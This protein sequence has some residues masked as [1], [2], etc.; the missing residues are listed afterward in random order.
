[1]QK[2]N[3]NPIYLIETILLLAMLFFFGFNFIKNSNHNAI[4]NYPSKTS[5]DFKEM[6]RDYLRTDLTNLD[7]KKY[8]D[9]EAEQMIQNQKN[10]YPFLETCLTAALNEKDLVRKTFYFKWA[11]NYFNS[12]PTEYQNTPAL[13]IIQAKIAYFQRKQNIPSI[14]SSIVFDKLKSVPKNHSFYS[15]AQVW[16]IRL[17]SLDQDT[18][19]IQLQ[20][21]DLVTNPDFKY[22]ELFE[23]CIT[24]SS[25]SGC[26]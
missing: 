4:I 12:I 25:E 22:K 24:H 18:E 15:Q 26:Q 23:K 10:T 3:L 13:T 19:S 16:K 8:F 9:N 2:S 11:L 20:W 6:T 14:E 21:R 1:M 7:F 17:M 5:L